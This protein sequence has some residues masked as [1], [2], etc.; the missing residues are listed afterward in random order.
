MVAQSA[1][2]TAETNKAFVTSSTALIASSTQAPLPSLAHVVVHDAPGAPRHQ[3]EVDGDEEGGAISLGWI[4]HL[5]PQQQKRK[6]S[7]NVDP[8]R[9]LETANVQAPFTFKEGSMD[10]NPVLTA[11]QVREKTSCATNTALAKLSTAFWEAVTQGS[12]PALLQVVVQESPCSPKT[13][14]S[15]SGGGGPPPP[16]S[17]RLS[18]RKRNDAR[19]ANE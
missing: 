7:P 16:P 19:P 17:L 3:P 9:L 5:G 18:F 12:F 6:D 8:Q 1:S 13:Q 4:S 10:R 14:S 2:R 11:S 15:I